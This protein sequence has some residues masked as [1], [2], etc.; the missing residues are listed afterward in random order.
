MSGRV[1]VVDDDRDMVTTLC[2]ILSLKGW[3]AE[4]AHSGEEALVR[5]RERKPNLVLMDI[6]MQ[7]MN[8]VDA[9]RALRREHP[10]LRVVLMTAY[11]AATLVDEAREAGALDVLRKPIDPSALLTFLAPMA[12]TSRR[13]VVLEDNPAFLETLSEAVEEA[14][15]E[16]HRALSLAEALDGLHERGAAVVLMDMVLPGSEPDECVWAI[17]EAS[18]SVMFVLYSGHREALARTKAR[19]PGEWVCACL[20]KPFPIETLIRTLD[21]CTS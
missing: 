12:D 21:D 4:G 1:L 19:V 20:Q 11:S 15:F 16:V 2:D 3:T 13:V 10:S 8:G 18:P 7:G 6:R 5:A 9:L 17:R 14:G